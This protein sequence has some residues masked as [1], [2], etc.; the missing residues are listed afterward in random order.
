LSNTPSIAELEAQ[1]IEAY[2]RLQPTQQGAV[3][4]TAATLVR[5][6]SFEVRLI[7]PLRMPQTSQA[8]F[9]ME[10]FDHDRQLSIDSVGDCVLEDAVIAAEDFIGRATRLSENPHSWRQST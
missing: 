4:L 7:Q 2:A 1:L 10:L 3:A 9:W 5:L 6:G 8:R